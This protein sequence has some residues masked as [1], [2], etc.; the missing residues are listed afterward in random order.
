[1]SDPRASR[2]RDLRVPEGRP[3]GAVGLTEQDSCLLSPGRRRAQAQATVDGPRGRGVG[4]ACNV[5]SAVGAGA[6]GE[7]PWVGPGERVGVCRCGVS[8]VGPV[9]GTR[10]GGSMTRGINPVHPPD[11]PMRGPL[12]PPFRGPLAVRAI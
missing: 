11:G 5:G 1:M 2:V 6:A 12:G 7:R 10:V 8:V 3:L 4:W 9:C